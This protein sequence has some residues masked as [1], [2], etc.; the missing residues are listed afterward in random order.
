MFVCYD[1]NVTVTWT[2]RVYK[3][4][5]WNM[6]SFIVHIDTNRLRSRFSK[7]KLTR[8]QL[9]EC[10]LNYKLSSSSPFTNQCLVKLILI[11]LTKVKCVL[12]AWSR[13]CNIH[14]M[15]FTM[16][17]SILCKYVVWS[18]SLMAAEK[19]F[20]VDCI[21]IRGISLRYL[22]REGLREAAW[23]AVAMEFTFMNSS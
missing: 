17:T 2:C 7:I 3:F 21:W 18:A 4:F 1:F 14:D 20:L 8:P 11:Y 16:V 5:Y 23:K 10:Q 9:T 12:I 15:L 22:K 13:T 19:E 6:S